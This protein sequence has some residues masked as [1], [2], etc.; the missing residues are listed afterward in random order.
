MG[1]GLRWK[2][3]TT[4]GAN[5]QQGAGAETM[6]GSGDED[7]DGGEGSTGKCRRK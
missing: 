5:P 7:G 2:R 6:V 1:A 4:G 3:R